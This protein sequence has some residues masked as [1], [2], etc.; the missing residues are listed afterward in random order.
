MF[1]R[2]LVIKTKVLDVVN[3]LVRPSGLTSGQVPEQNW[4][5]ESHAASK[6]NKSDTTTVHL[7]E[8]LTED[9]L[10][11]ILLT[12]VQIALCNVRDCS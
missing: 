8:C 2:Y 9:A 4:H 10:I 11:N 6:E 7:R 3:I 5:L 1:C 12:K